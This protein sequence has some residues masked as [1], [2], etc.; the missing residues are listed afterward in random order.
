M[1]LRDLFADCENGKIDIVLTKSISRFKKYGRPFG[2][3]QA[4]EINLVEV[5]FEGKNKSIHFP[6]T[7]N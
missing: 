1:N 6:G 3:R 7:E 2:N 4:F 5:R